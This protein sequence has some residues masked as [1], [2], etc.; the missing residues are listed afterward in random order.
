MT[1]KYQHTISGISG[2][3]SSTPITPADSQGMTSYSYLKNIKHVLLF[4]KKTLK[5]QSKQG[6]EN[7]EGKRWD[8]TEG[9]GIFPPKS[10]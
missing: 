5:T 1:Q 6:A 8:E 9:K 10:S 2:N 4:N 3:R 7:R